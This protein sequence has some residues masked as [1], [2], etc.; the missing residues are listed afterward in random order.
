M[1]GRII[2][3]P[4]ALYPADILLPRGGFEKWAV[5]ACDQ[6][7][8]EPAYWE[9][10]RKTVGDSPSALNMILPE[11]YLNDRPR[12]RAD[13]A[14]ATM[15][16]YLQNGVFDLREDSM[17]YVERRVSGGIRKGIV[18]AVDLRDYDPSPC[19]SSRIRATEET[20]PERVPPRVKMREKAPLE[21]PHTLLLIDD[22]GRTVIE[23]CE[24]RKHLFGKA[25]DFDLMYGGGRITGRFLDDVEKERIWSAMRSLD[26]GS[27][28][29]PLLA[30]GDG[31]HSLAAAKACYDRNPTVENRFSLAEIVNLRC[32]S[33]VFEPIYRLVRGA[34]PEKLA[35]MFL[36]EFPR[37][38]AGSGFTLLYG[39][40]EIAVTAERNGLP[41]AA[42]QNFL[43][44]AAAVMP[45]LTVDYIHGADTLR[46]LSAEP[47]AA[48][49]L[50]EGI[51]KEELFP[52]VAEN[53]SLPRK[54][55]S[56]GEANDKRYY[57]E[58]RKIT[59]LE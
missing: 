18:A 20:V 8:S 50:F 33:L 1:K 37:A 24:D 58:C 5:I 10:V 43:E 30:V 46:R 54:T 9:N 49:F 44:K 7:T 13:A 40:G 42:L 34:D 16:E 31:N 48:G 2:T 59:P 15:Y 52:A 19:A 38:E 6:H 25:Y 12:E 41:V 56:M 23:P 21:M 35:D 32:E 36:S 14:I 55:F 26:G 17:L 45:G 4:F 11:V 39:G 29:S 47:G 27:D 57:L 22:P 3:E 51:S 53:G 28:N